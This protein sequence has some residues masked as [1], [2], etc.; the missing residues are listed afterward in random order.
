[1][2]IGG[3]SHLSGDHV[4]EPFWGEAKMEYLACFYMTGYSIMNTF[5]SELADVMPVLKTTH[6]KG[7]V[8]VFDEAGAAAL[9]TVELDTALG[10]QFIKF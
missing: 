4:N 5:K 1:N 2:S 7:N 9:K 10:G 8:L 6:D 3:V